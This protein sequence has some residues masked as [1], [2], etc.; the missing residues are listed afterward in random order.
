MGYKNDE[1]GVKTLK[2]DSDIL[3]KRLARK[4]QPSCTLYAIS[5]DDVRRWSH[6]SCD[7]HQKNC[8]LLVHSLPFL[9]LIR[10]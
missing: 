7:V 10:K 9:R 1:V 3:A 6:K 8:P 2:L 4:C 5:G